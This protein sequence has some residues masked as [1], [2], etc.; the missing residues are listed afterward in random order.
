MLP[1]S[2]R[3]N[4]K[5]D[6]KYVASGRKLETKYLKL[7]MKEGEKTARIGIAVSSKTFAK[8]TQR[9]KAK[10]VA[11]VAFETIF[12]QLPTG[13]FIVAL[14]KASILEVKSEDVLRDLK[15]ALR[16]ARII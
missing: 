6:F 1:K 16:K 2:Q 7:F 15:E 5:K 10:R 11:S 12:S 8:S 4:L 3:V 14:P 9:N 13:I